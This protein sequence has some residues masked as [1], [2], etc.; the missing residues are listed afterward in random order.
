MHQHRGGGNTQ[1]HQPSPSPSF[2][3]HRLHPNIALMNR[4][5]RLSRSCGT[6][7]FG[8]THWGA[9]FPY[10]INC[11][12]LIYF[13]HPGA[14]RSWSVPRELL[15]AFPPAGRRGCSGTVRPDRGWGSGRAGCWILSS[16]LSLFFITCPCLAKL[17]RAFPPLHPKINR[18]S[19]PSRHRL[20]CYIWD[21]LLAPW[22]DGG[23]ILRLISP[24]LRPNSQQ[25][26]LTNAVTLPL[27]QGP[28]A[29]AL[30]LPPRWG[31]PL[32]KGRF[33]VPNQ[34]IV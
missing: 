25:P 29:P 15:G 22:K 14:A 28:L 23:Q 24:S 16:F 5:L 20:C 19:H 4:A 27:R 13:P 6:R 18:Q 31:T 2:Q 9:S 34:Q 3:T 11:I 26:E 17:P 8:L 21:P 12:I 32:T 10:Y 7:R 33:I 30:P 1:A